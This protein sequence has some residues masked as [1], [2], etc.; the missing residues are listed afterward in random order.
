[1][2][3][4]FLFLVII[5]LSISAFAQLEVKK[6]S[7]KEVPGFVNINIDKMYDD[8]DKPYA[9]VKVKTENINDRQRR[10]LLF[11]GDAATFFEIEYKVGEVWVYLSYYAS[12]LKISHPDFSSTEFYFPFD[13]EP[14]KG[15]ELILVN[16]SL[17]A[18]TPVKDQYNYL[19][20][21]T[22]RPEAMIYV[23][24][25]YEGDG[26]FSRS[27][28]V[29]DIHTWRIDCDF[30][31]S[32]SGQVTIEAGEPIK[33]EKT[34]RPDFGYV[35]VTTDPEINAI[36]FIDGAKVG[37]TP[38]KSEILRSGDHS[39]RTVKEMYKTV[40]ETVY[41]ENGET[42][43]VKA[44][45][46]A[47]FVNV[48]VK[49]DS[50]SDIY[51]DNVLKGKGSWKGVMPT[52]LHVFEARKDLHTTSTETKELVPGNDMS[53]IIPNP[54]PIC[55]AVDVNSN[56]IGANIIIDG[57]NYGT[58]PR[59]ISNL[60]IGTH[61]L[62]LEMKGYNTIKTTIV[63]EENDLLKINETLQSTKPVKEK[64]VKEQS[65]KV[66][67]EM[68][69]KVDDFSRW[70]FGTLNVA[71]NN[72]GDL[73]Y[74]LTFGSVKKI[75]WFASV[76]SNFNFGGMSSD[77]ECGNDYLVNG[78]YIEFTGTEIF[79]ALS[80]TAGMI[81][82]L[83]EPMA[84]RIGAGYGIRNV[85]YELNDNKKAK[86][87]DLSAAGLDVT[88]GVQMKFGKWMVSVDAVSTNF[89]YFDAKLGLGIMF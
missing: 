86:N 12:F 35:Y 76:M 65:E 5:F 47:N 64:P 10:E 23:D 17:L 59:V 18:V 74:G 87:T 9:V 69:K 58:T 4:F 32:E 49:S 68:A 11:Q 77:Y 34:L 63:V 37:V 13:L 40:E 72:Y 14:K 41:I 56:P 29:G 50:Q 42:Y 61:E 62:K 89:K 8:N 27:Y 22:D 19:I 28:K 60:I 26:Q 30:Y 53:I 24:N 25:V 39:V 45:M 55:G 88:A 2:K 31:H 66:K 70:R 21:N 73:S 67:P 52:G 43:S 1:M 57:K 7:F 3:R 16:K 71:I 75:G 46:L 80:V 15:Y 48:S 6:D 36:V 82:R 44:R 85:V 78:E 84:V 54:E 81:Y 20:I 38:Y 79:T 51:I 83:S 33:I